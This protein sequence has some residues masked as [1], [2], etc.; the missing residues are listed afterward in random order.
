MIRAI[1]F[2]FDGVLVLT[3]QAR[4]DAVQKIAKQ[5]GL[6]IKS[7]LYSKSVGLTTKDF[8]EQYFPN[9]AKDKLE[10]ITTDYK[11]HKSSIAG[12]VAPIDFTN[13]FI[14]D[15]EGSKL[16]ALTSG[17]E[18]KFI[19][20][21]L[22]RLGLL[23]KFKLIIGSEHAVRHK[24]DPEI[25]LY[26]ADQLG[27]APSECIVIED[28]VVGVQAANRAGMRVYGLL[29]GTNSKTDFGSSEVGGFISSLSELKKVLE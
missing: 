6:E 14:R 24:P 26:T 20:T 3:S 4:F 5:H 21:V 11:I 13:E 15:Y 25:Y 16:L 1:I 23:S 8:L 29:N 22:L 27:V 10:K 17:N 19:E 28:S 12:T 18:T 7:D 2:D 9:L